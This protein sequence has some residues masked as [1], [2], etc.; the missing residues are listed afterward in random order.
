MNNPFFRDAGQPIPFDQISV[1][2]VREATDRII[3]HV[4]EVKRAIIDSPVDDSQ[5]R[6][7]GRDIMFDRLDVILSPIYLMKET[8]PD[9]EVRN[10]CQE[11]VEKLFNFYNE[12]RLDEALYRSLK[13]FA[14]TA[15]DLA[16]VER[17]YMEKAL[18]AYHRNG[19][20]LDAERRGKLKELDD[21]LSQKELIFQKNI[22]ESD[23]TLTLREEEMKGLPADFINSHRREDGSYAVTTR[24]PDYFPVLK[25]AEDESVRRRLYFSYL[26]RAREQNLPLL[27]EIIKLR[28][29]RIEL[30]GFKTYADYNLVDVMAKNPETVWSFLD[31]L[32][33]KV[34]EKARKD[35]ELLRDYAD[36]DVV[37]PWDRFFYTNGYKEGHFQLDE[38]EVK[39]YFSLDSVLEGVFDLVQQLYG[40][41]VVSEP[42][43]PIWHPEVRAFEVK[44][45]GEL[46]GRFYLDLFPR[47]NK[48]SHAA[49]FGLQSGRRDG[50]GYQPP[51]SAL[52]CNFNPPVEGKP[53]LLTHEEVETLFHE[54]GHLLHQLLTTSPLASFA[55]T[56]VSRDFVEMPSQIMENW[57]WEKAALKRF[58]RHYATGDPIPDELVDRMLAVKHLNSAV[59]IQQQLFYAVLD[60]TY[61][62]GFTPE[63][64]EDTTR[65]VYK[66]QKERTLFPVP[67]GTAMQ[68]SFGHL[69]GYAAAYYGYLWSRVYADDM[70]SLFKE[71]G[72][73]SQETG[74]RFRELVLARGDCAEP[75]TLI[76]EFLGREPKMDAFLETIG[77]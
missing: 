7:I 60:M 39:Q 27:D 52:V 12:L 36:T 14:D 30:L 21:L 15:P 2:H 45:Q 16:P 62:H 54:F 1:D 61:H 56:S 9:G 72:I 40:V 53:S 22:S 29:E 44:D 49:C 8:H 26:N 41:D 10:A 51:Y 42:T 23:V 5:A 28:I 25:M 4:K 33:E 11:S 35:Y 66:I 43:L 17:R 58:A 57:V 31:E 18:D 6:L 24:Y 63:T 64:P 55:G 76:Q 20:Q 71:N 34:S 59:D 50:S 37:Q 68:A 67:Q 3:E 48:Y 46:V 38:E 32:T 65:L 73:Y 13:D 69:I 74:K 47:P 19:F 70:F 75:M 77:V